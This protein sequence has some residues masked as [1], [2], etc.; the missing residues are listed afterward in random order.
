VWVGFVYIRSAAKGN[1]GSSQPAWDD[2]IG[3]YFPA[4][5]IFCAVALVLRYRIYEA[6]STRT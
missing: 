2:P 4:K 1:N 3:I 6:T 5:G